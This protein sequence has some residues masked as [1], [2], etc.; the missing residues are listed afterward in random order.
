[1][2]TSISDTRIV[3]TNEGTGQTCVSYLSKE[4]RT[5]IM[6]SVSMGTH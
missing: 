6:I 1:M 2:N 5:D 4:S 3:G